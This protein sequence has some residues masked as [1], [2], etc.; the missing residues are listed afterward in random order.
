MGSQ[1]PQCGGCWGHHITKWGGEEQTS[2]CP[3][4]RAHQPFAIISVDVCRSW[5]RSL[6]LC[7]STRHCQPSLAIA[8]QVHGVMWWVMYCQEAGWGERRGCGRWMEDVGRREAGGRLLLQERTGCSWVLLQ[9]NRKIKAHLW[10]C[11]NI[12]QHSSGL[13]GL[14]LKICTPQRKTSTNILLT[15]QGS[16]FLQLLTNAAFLHLFSTALTSSLCVSFL[17]LILLTED[18]MLFHTSL[19][20]FALLV[21]VFR[22]SGNMGKWSL[23]GNFSRK[24]KKKEKGKKCIIGSRTNLETESGRFQCAFKFGDSCFYTVVKEEL[25]LWLAMVKPAFSMWSQILPNP[26]DRLLLNLNQ[27]QGKLSSL[28]FQPCP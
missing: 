25:Y 7:S 9:T 18:E 12:Q 8:Q 3:L 19:V 15:V 22:W 23:G 4:P 27:S 28:V 24:K 26:V 6:A 13:T 17:Y 14:A 5:W 10:Q 21:V 2:L 20:L 11:R 16:F 1:L